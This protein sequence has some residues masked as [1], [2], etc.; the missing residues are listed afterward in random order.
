VWEL[1]QAES[2]KAPAASKL[3]APADRLYFTL[4]ALLS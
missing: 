3:T 1:L 4:I 2:I